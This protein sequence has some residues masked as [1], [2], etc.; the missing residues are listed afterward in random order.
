M[1]DNDP[2]DRE[3]HDFFEQ[4]EEE[5]AERTRVHY[6]ALCSEMNTYGIELETSEQHSLVVVASGI[7]AIEDSVHPG[8]RRRLEKEFLTDIAVSTLTPEIRNR[9]YAYFP[10]EPLSEEDMALVTAKLIEFEE[11]TNQHDAI[12]EEFEEIL[13]D[14]ADCDIDDIEFSP[15]DLVVSRS[16]IGDFHRLR[17]ETSDDNLPAVR[18]EIIRSVKEWNEKYEIHPALLE[19]VR[20]LFGTQNS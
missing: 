1:K 3:I 16:L 7:R 14:I 9:I 6:A 20:R 12:V 8:E 10:L 2:F 19:L 11:K 5:A 18:D 4:T 13:E 17:H 15:I